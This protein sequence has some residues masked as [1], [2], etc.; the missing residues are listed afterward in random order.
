MKDVGPP[1]T[2]RCVPMFARFASV[3]MVLLVSRMPPASAVML[4]RM[5][6]RDS[7]PPQ[8]VHHHVGCSSHG[9]MRQI[10]T[11][12]GGSSL[13]CG[14]PSSRIDRS[15]LPEPHQH[16]DCTL[17]LAHRVA[18]RPRHH[19]KPPSPPR[20]LVCFECSTGDSD[21]TRYRSVQVGQLTLSSLESQAGRRAMILTQSGQMRHHPHHAPV[22][23]ALV[24]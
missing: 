19:E 22:G 5:H 2:S 18:P 10:G 20:L 15:S 13:Q 21:T 12:A 1:A 24:A 3:P 16:H 6:L 8:T 9:P 17:S 4:F 23:V 14:D 7:P 11:V